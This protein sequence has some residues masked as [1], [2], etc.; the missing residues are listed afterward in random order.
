MAGQ[1]EPVMLPGIGE[2]LRADIEQR[3]TEFERDH[4]AEVFAGGPG[5]VPRVRAADYAVAIIVN[6]AIAVW[7]VVAL[8]GG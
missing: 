3:V 5:W 8:V 1:R 2:D 6:L 4:Q 7:L